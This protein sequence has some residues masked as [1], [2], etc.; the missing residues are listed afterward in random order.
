MS[1]ETILADLDLNP[2][3]LLTYKYTDPDAGSANGI[4]LVF[5]W[6]D[7]IYYIDL[8]SKPEIASVLWPAFEQMFPTLSGKNFASEYVAID[9]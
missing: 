7:F 1:G 6:G 2:A 3:Y 4:T 8:R 9:C 5:T